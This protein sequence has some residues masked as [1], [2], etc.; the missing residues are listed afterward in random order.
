LT[1]KE[2]SQLVGM[3]QRLLHPEGNP[4]RSS[5]ALLQNLGNREEKVI[6]TQVV[7]RNGEIRDVS[8]KAGIIEVD[9]KNLLQVVFRDTTENKK[10]TEKCV[11]QAQLLNA[12]GIATMAVNKEGIITFWNSKAEQLFGWPE[13]KAMGHSIME[14]FASNSPAPKREVVGNVEFGLSWTRE[15]GLRRP[16]GTLLRVIMTVSPVADENGEI[17]GG[18]GVATAIPNRCN[19]NQTNL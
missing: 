12:I 19:L 4:W 9:N 8:V 16:D 17:I 13:S 7:G 18:V 6:E 5:D 2:K 11:F 15:I 1:G 14:I 10:V 3:H